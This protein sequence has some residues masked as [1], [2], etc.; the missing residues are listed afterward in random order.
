MNEGR[1]KLFK[2]AV[3]GGISL[4]VGK[5]FGKQVM[6]F[7]SQGEKQSDGTENIATKQ[8]EDRVVFFDRKTGEEIFVLDN[9]D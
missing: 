9:E 2:V 6:A 8:D 4:L 7:A 1:R 5:F 3:F